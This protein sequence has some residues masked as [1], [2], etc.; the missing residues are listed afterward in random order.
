[1]IGDCGRDGLRDALPARFA[2]EVE[3]VEGCVCEDGSG[4]VLVDV[5][6]QL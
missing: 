5:F 6:E 3:P 2:E 1:M 4:E